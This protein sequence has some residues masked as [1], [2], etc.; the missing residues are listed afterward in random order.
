MLARRAIAAP[1]GRRLEGRAVRGAVCTTQR[2]QC[3]VFP[4]YGCGFFGTASQS[5]VPRKIAAAFLLLD[6][7]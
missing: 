4:A 2:G 3:G 6:L 7:C 5:R 1:R